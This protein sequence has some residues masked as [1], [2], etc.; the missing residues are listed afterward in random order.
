MDTKRLVRELVESPEL[1][2]AVDVVRELTKR[3]MSI[4][5]AQEY[6]RKYGGSRFVNIGRIGVKKEYAIQLLA[7][8]ASMVKRLLAER[9]KKRLTTTEVYKHLCG[10]R[11]MTNSQSILLGGLLRKVAAYKGMSRGRHYVFSYSH[12]AQFPDIEPV[13]LKKILCGG[14]ID[15]NEIAD[16]VREVAWRQDVVT[17]I[18]VVNIISKSLGVGEDQVQPCV[19]MH[20]AELVQAGRFHPLGDVL[21]KREYVGQLLVEAAAAVKFVL[22]GG[23]ARMEDVAKALCGGTA[24]RL[25]T[26]EALIDVFAESRSEDG[27]RQFRVE[28]FT[29]IPD[30]EPQLLRSVVCL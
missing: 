23:V 24:A 21:V 28:R 10:N 5:V 30:G 2:T 4:R 19:V 11:V 7:E 6:V 17:S 3:G 13:L 1:V 29:Y 9:R 22:Q 8:T 20:L 14:S 18:D 16:V 27:S 12:L 15:C 26:L 25:Q